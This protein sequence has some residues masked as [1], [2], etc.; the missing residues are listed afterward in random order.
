MKGAPVLCIDIVLVALL[1][2]SRTQLL[3][4]LTGQNM[5]ADSDGDYAS[6]CSDYEGGG[7][8]GVVDLIDS[9]AEEDQ[10]SIYTMYT[11]YY[12]IYTLCMHHCVHSSTTLAQKAN[13]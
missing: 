13:D 11:S 8:G 4:L 1:T 2:H 5:A 7:G 10:V 3:L 9:D 6:G 12:I